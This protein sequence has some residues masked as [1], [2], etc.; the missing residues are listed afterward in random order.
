[1]ETIS[2]HDCGWSVSFTAAACPRCGSTEP[3]GPYRHN[4]KEARRLRAEDRNDRNLIIVMTA[5][6]AI[7]AFY[8][9]ETSSSSLG[10][11]MLGLWYGFVGVAIGAPL[12]FAINITRNWR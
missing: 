2:C 8:G 5:L 6:G 10:A 3:T 7:G 1:M 11:L 12:A 9:V 4:S